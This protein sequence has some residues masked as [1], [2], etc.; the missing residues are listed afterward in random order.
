MRK[1]AKYLHDAPTEALMPGGA[2]HY[3]YV[4][5]LRRAQQTP[6]SP[7][8]PLT[9]PNDMYGPRPGSSTY[10]TFGPSPSS[11]QMPLSEGMMGATTFSN[12]QSPV[13]PHF[14][15]GRGQPSSSMQN[16]VQAMQQS[17]PADSS[18][19]MS[20]FD[21]LFDPNDLNQY[22]FDPTSFNFG[23]HYGALEFGMLGHMSSGAAETPPGE[24]GNPMNQNSGNAF[25]P[26]T[27]SANYS[28]S[29][30]TAQHYV[31]GQDPSIGEWRAPTQ[32]Q[33]NIRGTDMF[34]NSRK[35]EGSN[36]VKQEVPHAF[37]IGV[38]SAFASPTSE[39]SPQQ[40]KASFDDNASAKI[41][42]QPGSA[43]SSR[44]GTQ[45]R[46]IVAPGQLQPQQQQ[47]QQQLY[48]QQ[49]ALSTSSH[50]FGPA[51]RRGDPSV[52]YEAVTQPY[53][54]TS[55][56]HSLIAFLKKRL[57]SQKTLRIAKA[58]A[59]IRPSFIS[60]TK[61]LGRE[62]LVFMEKCFQRT[63]WEYEDFINACGTPTIVCRRTGEIAAVGKEFSILTGWKK[64]ILLGREANLNV[65][66]GGDSGSA[67]GQTTANTGPSSSRGGMNTPRVPEGA[68]DASRP[69]SVFLPELLDDDSVIE[70]YEDFA[71]LAFGDSKGIVTTRCKLLK[72]RSKD[73]EERAAA[74]EASV[75][76]EDGSNR[77]PS[78]KR[79][80]D[81]G[82]RKLQGRGEV[83]GEAG[84]DEL[85][86]KDGKVECSCCWTVKRDLFDLPMMIVMNVCSLLF[87]PTPAFLY[88]S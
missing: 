86:D 70:F 28:G 21:G 46:S 84:I 69:Q 61:T 41:L 88:R 7:N 38:N 74:A 56:F 83:A 85:G 58:L 78:L 3:Q 79:K 50:A 12:Q 87:S 57:S 65:N 17:A 9:S 15:G 76:G 4:D 20:G 47:Q 14:Q 52:I 2:S 18:N 13:S 71:R 22:D 45:G 75:A 81:G 33:S 39:R 60:C 16:L 77:R 19:G 24:N 23:N 49:T 10:Q 40:M 11:S 51:R 48:Q 54:Y 37:S 6:Q 67:S 66:T 30:V 29:P 72:Y 5:N 32:P 55:G 59:S 1:K 35:Q 36:G 43:P 68:I 34:G 63:L 62:D 44:P 53:S 31:F 73:D 42:F 80:R 26:S 8:F 82:N 64:D 27:L 25:T